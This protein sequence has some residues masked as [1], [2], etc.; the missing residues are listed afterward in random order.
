VFEL[1][2]FHCCRI[3]ELPANQPRYGCSA[4]G[5]VLQIEWRGAHKEPGRV[6]PEI[7]RNGLDKHGSR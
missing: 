2:C 5:A 3:V 6:P 7:A 1:T 4:C